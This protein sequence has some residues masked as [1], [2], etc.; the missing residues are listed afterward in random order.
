M[1]EDIQALICRNNRC[2]LATVS[3]DRPH[4]SLMSYVA[5]PQC[6]E[7]YM[8][9]LRDTRKFAN[10]LANPRASLLIDTREEDAG[11]RAG[12]TKAVTVHGVFRAIAD[13]AKKAAVR[14]QL[15]VAHPQLQEFI[16]NPEAELLCISVESVLLLEGVSE[17]Y[18]EKLQ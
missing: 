6:R 13:P 7:L 5:D 17:L 1:R 10:L 15:A 16:S 18:F 11:G 4:C 12:G 8:V 14:A 2:V 3:G 9:T